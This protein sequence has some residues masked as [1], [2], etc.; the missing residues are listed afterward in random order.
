MKLFIFLT[1]FTL[2]GCGKL[3]DEIA[4]AIEDQFLPPE[5]AI[6]LEY[7]TYS[8]SLRGLGCTTG[9]HEF[10]TRDKACKSLL[11]NEANNDCA[12]QARADLYSK[13]CS[14]DFEQLVF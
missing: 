11:N 13:E 8:Y 2:V 1:L 7:E 10:D 5:K 12:K 3:G 14:G 9:F 4:G 6:E